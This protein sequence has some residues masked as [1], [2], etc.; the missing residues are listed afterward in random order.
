MLP[1]FPF[2]PAMS[3]NTRTTLTIERYRSS[4]VLHATTWSYSFLC[5]CVHYTHKQVSVCSSFEN[6]TLSLER[7]RL[8]SIMIMNLASCFAFCPPNTI[9]I[10]FYYSYQ[11]DVFLLKITVVASVDDNQHRLC[12]IVEAP[13]AGRSKKNFSFFSQGNACGKVHEFDLIIARN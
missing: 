9:L 1:T 12:K 6:C 2:G 11:F 4:S 3:P 7:K 8:A 5:V 13:N 10:I